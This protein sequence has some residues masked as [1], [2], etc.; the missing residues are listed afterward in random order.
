MKVFIYVFLFLGGWQLGDIVKYF[1][2]S[3]GYTCDD[4]YPDIEGMFDEQHKYTPKE[5]SATISPFSF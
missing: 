4:T 1:I 2:E 3:S 5:F